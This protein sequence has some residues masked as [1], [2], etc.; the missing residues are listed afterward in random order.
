MTVVTG[1]M[2]INSMPFSGF[3]I[4]LPS[5][6]ANTASTPAITEHNQ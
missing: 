1:T 2:F 4:L 3:K 5:F 6:H